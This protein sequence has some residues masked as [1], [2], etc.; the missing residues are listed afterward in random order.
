MAIL[1]LDTF[2]NNSSIWHANSLI[3][4]W[5]V[6]NLLFFT[7]MVFFILIT[8]SALPCAHMFYWEEEP[9]CLCSMWCY[10]LRI[11]EKDVLG[12]SH[13]DAHSS[14]SAARA[15][16]DCRGCQA[17]IFFFFFES[18]FKKLKCFKKKLK[19]RSTTQLFITSQS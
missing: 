9:H 7:L 4:S 16:T 8:G 2:W 13:I 19:L 3:P 12:S 15:Y 1:Y 6:S 10:L 18:K 11:Q 14:D 17:L 5:T